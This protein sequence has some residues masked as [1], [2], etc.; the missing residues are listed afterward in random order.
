MYT[1]R[2]FVNKTHLKIN[3]TCL[4]KLIFM[5]CL[6]DKLGPKKKKKKI[7]RVKKIIFTKLY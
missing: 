3:H 2:S 7:S 6:K 1:L 5:L 4:K